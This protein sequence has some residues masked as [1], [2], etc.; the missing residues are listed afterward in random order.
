MFWCVLSL[1]RA[2]GVIRAGYSSP[3]SRITSEPNK[4]RSGTGQALAES[5]RFPG[6][7]PSRYAGGIKSKE[8][9]SSVTKYEWTRCLGYSLLYF[10]TALVYTLAL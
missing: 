1:A 8:E 9:A 2:D 3:R 10:E 7:Q 4:D 6:L 5:G